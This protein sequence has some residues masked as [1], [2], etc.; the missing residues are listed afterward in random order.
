[1]LYGVTMGWKIRGRIQLIALPV[2]AM[3]ACGGSRRVSVGDAGPDVA[4]DATALAGTDLAEVLVLNCISS[5]AGCSCAPSFDGGVAECS[6]TTESNVNPTLQVACCALGQSFCSC[7]RFGCY[8]FPTVSQCLCQLAVDSAQ[9]GIPAC[10]ARTGVTCCLTTS[11]VPRC[12]C[13]SKL[14]TDT[15]RPVATCSLSDVAVCEDGATTT[16][17]CK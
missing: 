3:C 7:E 6:V 11:P 17:V 10:P 4:P 16:L 9:T 2:L 5:A 8:D 15:E 13:S 14:C 12:V 1:M